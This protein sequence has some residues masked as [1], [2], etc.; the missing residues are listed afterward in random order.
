MEPPN[1]FREKVR[2]GVPQDR[3]RVGIVRI[4]GCQDLDRLAVLE[5]QPQVV[6]EAVG[7]DEH[8]LLRELRPDRARGIEPRGA[9]GQLELGPVG[10]DDLH[11]RGG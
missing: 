5:G 10:Q 7:T 8:R 2:G 11:G 4:A 3:E 6:Y 1:G 9:V